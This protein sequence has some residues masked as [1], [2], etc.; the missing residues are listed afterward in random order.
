MDSLSFFFF[1]FCGFS[2]LMGEK[3]VSGR[4]SGVR[5]TTGAVFWR[6]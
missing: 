6:N 1:F 5:N 3:Q 4:V 2:F